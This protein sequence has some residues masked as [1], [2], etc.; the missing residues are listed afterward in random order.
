MKVITIFCWGAKE[1]TLKLGQGYDSVG[2]GTQGGG[3]WVQAASA[4]AAASEIQRPP[5]V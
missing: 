1:E 4:A 5:G 2:I 3:W